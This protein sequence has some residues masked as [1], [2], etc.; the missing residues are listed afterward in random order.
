MSPLARHD[1]AILQFS[2]GKDS[3][4]CLHLL[5][6]HWDR[7]TVMWVNTGA[8]FPETVKQMQEVAKLVKFVEVKSDQPAHLKEF[9]PPADCVPVRASP[10][11]RWAMQSDEPPIQSSLE[12]CHANL[13]APMAKAVKES[14][15]RLVIRGQ[16]RADV[17]RSP[18]RSGQ[19]VDGIEYWF[20]IEDWKEDRV[21]SYLSDIGVR[22]PAHYSYVNSS[23]DC[24]SCTAY[25]DHVVGRMEYMKAQHPD[26]HAQVLPMLR[27]IK[28]GVSSE[29]AY[30]ER[31]LNG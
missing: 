13:W 28:D 4:A 16:R 17:D 30:V 29:M 18:I 14:G 19:V 20:P 21:R 26:L 27:R 5:R 15:I 6:E 11:G 22:L 1:Q 3:L 2:G 7:L 9:G 12:C 23:L 25:R 8:A 10:F 31:A 24:W